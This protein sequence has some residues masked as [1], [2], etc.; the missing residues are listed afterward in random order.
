MTDFTALTTPAHP[1]EVRGF[2]QWASDPA[3]GWQ[4]MPQ[5]RFR[6]SDA[7]STVVPFMV[8]PIALVVPIVFAA[9]RSTQP[10]TFLPFTAVPLLVAALAFV[11]LVA[12]SRNRFAGFD[13]QSMYRVHEFAEDNGLQFLPDLARA[14]ASDDERY[15]AHL[16]A[17]GGRVYHRLRSTSGRFFEIGSHR[18]SN[19]G[20]STEG[21][22][23]IHRGYMAVKLDRQLPQ[24][25]LEAK[26]NAGFFGT[27]RVGDTSVVVTL[28]GD[29]N[30][31]FTLRVPMGYERDALYVFTPD[32]MALLIDE[33]SA[34]DVE[35]IDDWMFIYSP[36]PF[37]GADPQLYERLF[38]ILSTV[39]VKAVRQASRYT[40]PRPRWS[41]AR[42]ARFVR[43]VP[44]WVVVVGWSVLAAFAV[45]LL[46]SLFGTAIIQ[47]DF[48]GS[49]ALHQSP[50]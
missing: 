7:L 4:P 14:A 8:V 43:G 25:V 20:S 47:V 9:S 33:S 27:V 34:F 36:E 24:M 11:S 40:D 49:I 1:D 42:G 17:P 35:L 31:Y 16:F 12:Q 41:G 46:L 50:E 19:G 21:T 38:R 44:L 10:L 22:Y 3:R 5:V 37:V 13:W 6:F 45:V 26:A 39:G 15:P 28:E 48:D 18:R 30:E 23:Y 29:F 32:L 2:A